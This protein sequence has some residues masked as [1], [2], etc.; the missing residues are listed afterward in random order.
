MSVSAVLMVSWPLSQMLRFVRQREM[1]TGCHCAVKPRGCIIKLG[2]E[3]QL[4][5]NAYKECHTFAFT[6]KSRVFYWNTFKMH[7]CQMQLSALLH[8]YTQTLCCS[9]ASH[10]CLGSC[11]TWPKK[12][13]VVC[14]SCPLISCD[15][16]IPLGRL[17]QK[18]LL[19]FLFFFIKLHE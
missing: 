19:F 18:L 17:E 13:Y 5:R 16:C 7:I 8:T 15:R 6:T 1:K 14:T 10:V 3:Q 9:F 11:G 12:P 4:T 2:Q